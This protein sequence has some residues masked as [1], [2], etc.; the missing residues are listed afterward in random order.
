[1]T[2]VQRDVERAVLAAQDCE[3]LVAKDH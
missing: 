3:P 2:V 1:V